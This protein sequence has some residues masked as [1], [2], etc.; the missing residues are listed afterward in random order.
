MRS[1]QG[2]M[3]FRTKMKVDDAKDYFENDRN[4]FQCSDI[5]CEIED[6]QK[7]LHCGNVPSF[8]S[9]HH[10]KVPFWDEEQISS[11]F[12]DKN[13]IFSTPLKKKVYDD[14]D[15]L[16]NETTSSFQSVSLA[17]YEPAIASHGI[18]SREE[19]CWSPVVG[20]RSHTRV[21]EGRK[22]KDLAK[23]HGLWGEI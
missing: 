18:L 10:Q 20:D 19:R 3:D 13:S 11:S 1:P 21:H 2:V 7:I 5:N 8:S 6:F 9:D 4:K 22:R 15:L 16:L 12:A 14:D 23:I 17:E